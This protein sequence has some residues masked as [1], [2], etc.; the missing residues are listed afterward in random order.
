MQNVTDCEYI[1]QFRL[2]H[3]AQKVRSIGVRR[4]SIF[5]LVSKTESE[6]PS[7]TCTNASTFK[8]P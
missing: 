1:I 5:I 7:H 6:K 8:T 3:Y 2:K 4:N